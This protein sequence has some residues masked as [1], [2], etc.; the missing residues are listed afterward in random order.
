[1]SFS[2]E[3]LLKTPKWHKVVLM[4][5]GSSVSLGPK[6]MAASAA[7]I[8][9]CQYPNPA[10]IS[11]LTSGD[12]EPYFRKQVNQFRFVLVCAD[13]L[14]TPFYVPTYKGCSAGIYVVGYPFWGS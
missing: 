7:L 1:V 5:V 3:D 13:R 4:G 12:F 8:Q 11:L 6:I 14:A 9:S 2:V 10:F